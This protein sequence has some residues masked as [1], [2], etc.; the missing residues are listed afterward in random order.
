MFDAVH[1]FLSSVCPI[2]LIQQR[3]MSC[4]LFGKVLLTR[5]VVCRLS[6][7]ILLFVK[8]CLSVFPFGVWD[9]LWVLIRS[10]PE[11]SLLH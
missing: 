8:I 10:V 1:F 3:L 2:Y 9:G 5:L 11:V 7:V 6:S 4:H